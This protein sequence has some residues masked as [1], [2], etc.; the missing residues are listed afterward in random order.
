MATYIDID[1]VE[2]ENWLQ[3]RP[4]IIRELFTARPSGVYYKYQ[5]QNFICTIVSFFE[6][7]TARVNISGEFNLIYMSRSMIVDPYELTECDAP[8]EDKTLGEVLREE[9]HDEFIS[10]SRPYILKQRS[11]DDFDNQGI[12]S[13]LNPRIDRFV[14]EKSITR[15]KFLQD[16][17]DSIFNPILG[18]FFGHLI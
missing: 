3:V 9:E 13:F 18:S 10:L 7:R 16:I 4:P 6:D 12:V 5:E 8:P 15:E 17:N 14:Q 1:P 2:L 11:I